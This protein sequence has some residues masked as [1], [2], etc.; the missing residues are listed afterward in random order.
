[1]KTDTY[2]AISQGITKLKSFAR[3]AKL[4]H[5]YICSFLT[6]LGV[7]PSKLLCL[8]GLSLLKAAI[9]HMSINVLLYMYMIDITE[10]ENSVISMRR[11]R[12]SHLI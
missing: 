10:F 7:F 8:L 11:L 1:M 4:K 9:F 6:V 12:M 5:K 2:G 3:Q